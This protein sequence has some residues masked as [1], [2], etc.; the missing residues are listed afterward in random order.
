MTALL[1]FN[2]RTIIDDSG[3][4]VATAF[5]SGGLYGFATITDM[6]RE[7][8]RLDSYAFPGARGREMKALGIGDDPASVL[9]ITFATDG[10]RPTKVHHTSRANLHA[11]IQS[12]E[13]WRLNPS[14]LHGSL[15]YD[16]VTYTNMVWVDFRHTKPVYCGLT[17]GGSAKV[18]CSHL[19]MRFEA[20]SPAGGG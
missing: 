6:Q 16:G 13:A 15:V 1:T 12:L 14:N 5:T 7:Q 20:A 9:G 19:M 3:S 17:V 4:A 18:V 11:W 8:V 2:G 10:D